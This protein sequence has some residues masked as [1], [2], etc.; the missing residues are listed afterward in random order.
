MI[1]CLCGEEV[2]DPIIEEPFL[3]TCLNAHKEC[4]EKYKIWYNE[5]TKKIPGVKQEK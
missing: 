5:Y 4:W 2:D 3:A 1:C